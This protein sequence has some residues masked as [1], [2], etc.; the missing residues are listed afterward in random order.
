MSTMSKDDI[1]SYGK[2]SRFVCINKTYPDILLG[3]TRRAD[4]GLISL[5]ILVI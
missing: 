2:G 5:S 3:S 1:E 4:A